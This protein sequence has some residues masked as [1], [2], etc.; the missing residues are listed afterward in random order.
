MNS[1]FMTLSYH[2]TLHYTHFSKN[3]LAWPFLITC[4]T[5]NPNRSSHP[6]Y[7]NFCFLF[8][9]YVHFSIWKVLASNRRNRRSLDILDALVNWWIMLVK[10]DAEWN[11]PDIC[12]RFIFSQPT[13]RIRFDTPA[14][15]AFNCI[16]LELDLGH[17]DL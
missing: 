7:S 11:I 12:H 6:V 1:N 5:H 17:S 16:F 3:W 13:D 15:C 10:T 2:G 14:K 8:I 4:S 9:I